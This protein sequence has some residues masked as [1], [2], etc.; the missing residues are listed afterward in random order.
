MIWEGKPKRESNPTEFPRAPSVHGNPM[1][2]TKQ[3]SLHITY[4]AEKSTLHTDNHSQ[5]L[6][7][8]KAAKNTNLNNDNS[9]FHRIPVHGYGK[10]LRTSMPSV[11]T[12]YYEAFPQYQIC[13]R[14]IFDG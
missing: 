13:M 5:Y 8:I 6:V 7:I 10:L 1:N 12:S 9:S 4:E 3:L 14:L 11:G 2:E